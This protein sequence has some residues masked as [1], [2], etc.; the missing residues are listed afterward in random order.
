[1]AHVVE[2]LFF[3]N[4]ALRS[5]SSGTKQTN[6]QTKPKKLAPIPEKKKKEKGKV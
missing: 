1:M 2:C 6:K 4:K 5:N 3:K